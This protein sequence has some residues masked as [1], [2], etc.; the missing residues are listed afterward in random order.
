MYL[1]SVQQQRVSSQTFDQEFHSLIQ[2]VLCD[3]LLHE[4]CNEHLHY[5][6]IKLQ[7]ADYLDSKDVFVMSILWNGELYNSGI[8]GMK[9]G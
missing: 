7:S 2:K 9:K 5:A 4:S 8:N 6:S 1:H 3:V